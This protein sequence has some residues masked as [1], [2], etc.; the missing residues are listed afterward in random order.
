M[1]ISEIRLKQIIKE[2][3]DGYMIDN[4]ARLYRSKDEEQREQAKEI[5]FSLTNT[6]LE[7]SYC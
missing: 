4:L 3:L 6:S 5:L 1:I 2:E 7:K